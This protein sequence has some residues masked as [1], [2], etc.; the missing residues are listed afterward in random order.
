MCWCDCRGGRRT[1]HGRIRGE[2]KEEVKYISNGQGMKLRQCVS[3]ISNL[4]LFECTELKS[5]A[6]TDAETIGS[7]QIRRGLAHS[8]K[9]HRPCSLGQE[10]IRD[11]TRG[12]VCA[13]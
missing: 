12:L 2:G 5:V 13:V 11:S 10:L 3:A 8:A 9:K 7:S 6:G 1:D 4:P